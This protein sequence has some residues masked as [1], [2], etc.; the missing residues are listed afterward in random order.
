MRYITILLVLL[1]CLEVYSCSSV[2]TDFQDVVGFRFGQEVYRGRIEFG[3]SSDTL[4]T[5]QAIKEFFSLDKDDIIVGGHRGG[6]MIG[7]PEN[8]LYSFKRIVWK[9]P[10][11]F[12][13]D[14]R[15]T[16]DSVVVLLHDETL[17]RTTTGSGNLLD[18]SFQELSYFYLKDRGGN[19]MNVTIPSLEDVVAWSK[20][21]V[22]LNF[23]N[24]GVPPSTIIDII[25]KHQA[26]NCIF[27]VHSV[28]YA[29]EILAIAPEML[30]SAFMGS[31]AKFLQ[32]KNAGLL[33]H[34]VVAY[35]ESSE[36]ESGKSSLYK[37]IR[38]AGI[39][40]MVSTASNQD[41]KGASARMK[42]YLNLIDQHPDIIETD[43][44]VEFVGL[45]GIRGF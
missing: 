4:I 39:R 31:E 23:D 19:T 29:Q 45:Y 26:S 2:D 30:F 7:Y 24:K 12:E 20:D 10:T 25:R 5:T 37:M 8:S 40:I 43:F 38:D 36:M 21:K 15:M 44:P 18:Y 6:R 16:R 41:Y 22:I 35:V 13:V 11:F 33:D 17:D 14:P 42:A 34:I 1:I 9:I 27:T 28:R 32:Y 3:P